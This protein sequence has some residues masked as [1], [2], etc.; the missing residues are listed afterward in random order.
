MVMWGDNWWNADAGE[1][2]CLKLGDTV[3]LIWSNTRTDTRQTHSA[4]VSA[5]LADVLLSLH[6]TRYLLNRRLYYCSEW[7]VCVADQ[8]Y[9]A[10]HIS[11]SR[12]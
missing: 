9:G 6:R 3:Y 2:R 12:L 4:G 8:W 1:L 7:R 10:I 11:I 5:H